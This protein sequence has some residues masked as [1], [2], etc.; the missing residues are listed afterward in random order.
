MLVVVYN[1]SALCYSEQTISKPF[2]QELR[3][4]FHQHSM[5]ALNFCMPSC[6]VACSFSHWSKRS[7]AP[8]VNKESWAFCNNL[9]PLFFS[10]FPP[11]CWELN[12]HSYIPKQCL[13]ICHLILQNIDHGWRTHWCDT[14]WRD[15][16]RSLEHVFLW[17]RN[18]DAF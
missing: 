17:F 10:A 5:T 14:V 4:W 7:L 6:R 3:M 1:L 13:G 8:S 2:L 15:H 12:P 16:V 11:G 18:R 9:L